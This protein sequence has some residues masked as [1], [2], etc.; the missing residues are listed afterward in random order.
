MSGWP[1]RHEFLAFIKQ[2]Q[3]VH[4]G[5]HIVAIFLFTSLRSLDF[6]SLS[7]RCPFLPRPVFPL[8]RLSWSSANPRNCSAHARERKTRLF[9]TISAQ[10]GFCATP[11]ANRKCSAVGLPFDAN[12]AH[13]FSE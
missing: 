5:L 9:F 1:L 8:M 6:P 2:A 3:G 11:S 12:P 10:I 13:F 7:G 4:R